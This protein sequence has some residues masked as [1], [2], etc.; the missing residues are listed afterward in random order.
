MSCLEHGEINE[1]FKFDGKNG[2]RGGG[3]ILPARS[4]E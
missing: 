4:E 2:R 1:N 3:G